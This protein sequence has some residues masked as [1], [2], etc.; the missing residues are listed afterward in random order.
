MS[1]VVA[2]D[3][4]FSAIGGVETELKQHESRGE[5]CMSAVVA[6]CMESSIRWVT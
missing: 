2:G 6:R 4:S 1:A 3:A 5:F